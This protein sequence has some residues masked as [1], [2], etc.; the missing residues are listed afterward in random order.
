[1]GVQG[2][3]GLLRFVAV[4]KRSERLQA[5]PSRISGSTAHCGGSLNSLTLKQSLAFP[6]NSPAAANA[7]R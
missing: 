2:G 3:C 1:M 5:P 6:R 7:L 4:K